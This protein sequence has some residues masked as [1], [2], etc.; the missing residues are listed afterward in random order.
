MLVLVLEFSKI[1][2]TTFNSMPIHGKEDHRGTRGPTGI[3]QGAV[4]L[5]QNG[6][7]ELQT[8]MAVT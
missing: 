5:L 1:N 4:S 3:V 7:R 8:Y 6:R 2:A